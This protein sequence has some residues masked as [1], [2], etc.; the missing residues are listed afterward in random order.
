MAKYYIFKRVTAQLH[1][2]KKDEFF[3][4][5]YFKPECM[6]NYVHKWKKTIV[7]TE[8]N[9]GQLVCCTSTKKLSGI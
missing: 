2:F 9:M 5:W 4:S 7:E 1:N 6:H 8:Y 3:G